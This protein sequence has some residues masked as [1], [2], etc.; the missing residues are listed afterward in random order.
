VFVN[1]RGDLGRTP[2]L[3]RTDALVSHEVKLGGR[4]LRVELN[5]LNL[6]NQKT[7]RHE[8]TNLNRY[9]RSGSEINLS[10]VDL[11]KGYDYLALMNATAD[12]KGALTAKDPRFGMTDLFSDGITGTFQMKFIF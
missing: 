7:N 9:R 2:V 10:N 4:A 5:V 1:G 11:S 8:F 6:F 3:S 12:A